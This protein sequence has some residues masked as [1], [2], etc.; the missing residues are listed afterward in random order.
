[1]TRAATTIVIGSQ[2]GGVGKTTTSVHLAAAL[3]D[4]GRRC[5]LVDLDANQGA[6]A[7][8]GIDGEAY[9]GAAEVLR[10]EERLE[11]VVVSTADGA[12]L[13]RGVD[14]VPASSALETV[15][16]EAAAAA[17]PRALSGLEGRYDYV[18]LDTAPN[19]TPPTVEA[20]R[21][22]DWFLLSAVPEP[23]ALMGLRRAIDT[24][25]R[26]MDHGTARGRLL[27]VLFTAVH[28]RRRPAL[29]DALLAYAR[30]RLDVL[31]GR[32]LLLPTTISASSAVPR[33]Q[34]EGRT[35]FQSSPRHRVAR[36]YRQVA[37][38]VEKRIRAFGRDD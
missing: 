26:S 22:A 27:G 19:L 6:T 12:G 24:L 1:V 17:L 18:L 21:A 35:V 36:E 7:H 4:L 15:T 29:E 8:L 16:R 14:L 5:L 37:A 13:P 30:E 28:P 23:F 31:R 25:V 33:A 11:D 2:K 32:P 38:E 3:G 34:M 20:Y 9:E 10:G